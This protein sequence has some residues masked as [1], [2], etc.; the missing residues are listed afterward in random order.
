[1]KEILINKRN[2]SILICILL[3]PAFFIADRKSRA[4]QLY[5][6]LDIELNTQ[7][8]EYGS[9][10]TAEDLIKSHIG[11]LSIDK[12]LNTFKTGKQIITF[13]LSKTERRYNQDIERD[14][15]IEIEVTDTKPPVITLKENTVYTYTSSGYDPLNNIASAFDLID[16]K[17]DKPYIEGLFDLNKAGTYDIKAV[18]TD[19]NGN[20]TEKP[21]TLVVKNRAV[22][23]TEGYNIIYSHLTGA[24]GYNK[25]A[26]CG[27]LANIRYESNFDPDSGDTYYGLCQWGGNRQSNLFSYCQE[28]GLD[29][30]SIEGQ[31]EYLDY[32]MSSSYPAVKSYLM[33]IE[34][35]TSGAYS[36]A[37]YFCQNYE[38]AANAQGRGDLAVSYFNS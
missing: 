25:A 20:K 26:A 31:L 2:I 11:D 5:E 6:S 8:V 19:L 34:D 32:E 1:M 24:Y 38:G 35:S 13:T 3:I 36:A 15:P 33:N 4:K 27:I 29:A 7:T 21:F 28:N 12:E 23:P 17:I 10:I 18:A 14:F 22:T 30:S 37:E 9:D 16:G